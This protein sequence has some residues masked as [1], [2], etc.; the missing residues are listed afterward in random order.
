MS[1]SLALAVVFVL[2]GAQVARVARP[3]RGPYLL[4]LLL[5]A[6]GVLFG[7]L[8]AIALHSGGP[9]LGVLH[10]VADGVGIGVFEGVGTSLTPARRR[11]P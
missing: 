1:P 6:A 5:S 9:A 11:I 2:I 7:E 3:G 4:L 8:G 10:P